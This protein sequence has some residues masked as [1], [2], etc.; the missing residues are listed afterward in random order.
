MISW[1]VRL[2]LAGGGIVAEWF[3]AVD[4]PSFE[5]AQAAAATLLLALVVFVL[6]FFPRRWARRLDRR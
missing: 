3:I 4:S 6:A 5:I 2:L 1:I